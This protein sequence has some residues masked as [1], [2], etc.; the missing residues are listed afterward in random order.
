ML[1]YPAVITIS[2]LNNSQAGA[3]SLLWALILPA[4]ICRWM[5]LMF[6]LDGGA[7][8]ACWAPRR[9]LLR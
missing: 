1:K 5:V 9:L 3:A 2:E 6:W 7:Y 8:C 4:R